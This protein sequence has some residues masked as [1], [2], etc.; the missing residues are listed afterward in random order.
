MARTDTHPDFPRIPSTLSGCIASSIM[1]SV[2]QATQKI[3]VSCDYETARSLITTPEFREAYA[4][5]ADTLHADTLHGRC[6][7]PVRFVIV[8]G[9]VE[10]MFAT[11][12]YSLHLIPCSTVARGCFFRDDHPEREFRDSVIEALG[13]QDVLFSRVPILTQALNL[14][15][16]VATEPAQFIYYL[17]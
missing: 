6:W 9:L 2:H 10:W 3:T 4:L 13:A 16:D 5:A 17:P 15:E 14:I 8:S 7:C 12:T 11:N 1:K